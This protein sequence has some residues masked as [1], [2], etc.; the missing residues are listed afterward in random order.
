VSQGNGKYYF[1]GLGVLALLFLGGDGVGK[2]GTTPPP[3]PPP[4]GSVPVFWIY[5]RSG[6]YRTQLRNEPKA[7]VSTKA[8]PGVAGEPTPES[9]PPKDWALHEAASQAHAA[10][11]AGTFVVLVTYNG[12]AGAVHAMQKALAERDIP[13]KQ[14]DR[15]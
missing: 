7:P 12:Q 10:H 15:P 4:P 6:T 3:P 1:I 14:Y 2:P 13:Y 5:V 8:N 11:L 9:Y